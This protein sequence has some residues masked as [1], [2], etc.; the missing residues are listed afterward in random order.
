MG[1]DSNAATE[2][3]FTFGGAT[4][5]RDEDAEGRGCEVEMGLLNVEEE[6]LPPP[7]WEERGPPPPL[8]DLWT[9]PLMV[10]APYCWAF[11]ALDVEGGPVED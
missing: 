11:A 5:A 2:K 3:D 8:P 10:R 9:K 4:V 7:D 6:A 1:A